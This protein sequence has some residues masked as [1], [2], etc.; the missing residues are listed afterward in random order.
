ML[1][2]MKRLETKEQNSYNFNSVMKGQLNMFSLVLSFCFISIMLIFL[3][4]SACTFWQNTKPYMTPIRHLI[5]MHGAC[6]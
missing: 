6:A 3:Y 5:I 4:V 1:V 2:C